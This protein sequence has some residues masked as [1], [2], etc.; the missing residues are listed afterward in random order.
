MKFEI[1]WW[2]WNVWKGLMRKPYLEYGGVQILILFIIILVFFFFFPT[3]CVIITLFHFLFFFLFSLHLFF[4]SCLLSE[5]LSLLF[6]MFLKCT[7]IE[8]NSSSP[9]SC[10]KFLCSPSLGLDSLFSCFLFFGSIIFF[11]TFVSFCFL[12]LFLS[13]LYFL[14]LLMCFSSFPMLL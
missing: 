7:R 14:L 10:L 2:H 5:A 13:F 8:F 9:L 11:H 12:L 1:S 6:S 3:A 4:S